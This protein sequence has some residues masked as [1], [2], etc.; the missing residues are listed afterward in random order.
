VSVRGGVHGQEA[1]V[2]IV[3][4]WW[5]VPVIVFLVCTAWA[6]LIDDGGSLDFRPAIIFI[7]G[8]VGAVCISVGHFL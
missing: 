1:E 6:W 2:T 7:A 5:A 3:L 8:L 4:H